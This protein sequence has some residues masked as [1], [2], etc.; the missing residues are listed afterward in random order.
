MSPGGKRLPCRLPKGFPDYNLGGEPGLTVRALEHLA[1]QAAGPG[2]RIRSDGEQGRFQED[3]GFD[4]VR[5]TAGK[6]DGDQAACAAADHDCRPGT[7]R[8]QDCR[9][10]VDMIHQVQGR[11]RPLRGTAVET[12]AV[13]DDA[14]AMPGEIGCG[15]RPHHSRTGCS[16]HA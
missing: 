5:E 7:A 8:R 10:V 2:V 6:F 13:V 11:E 15:V 16:V 12:P 3:Q 9:C 4:F 1:A 14:A